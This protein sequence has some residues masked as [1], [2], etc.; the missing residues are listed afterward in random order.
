MVA[1]KFWGHGN[2][3]TQQCKGRTETAF[4]SRLGTKDCSLIFEE[5]NLFLVI[6][7]TNLATKKY[8]QK[9]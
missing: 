8:M 1:L 2:T 7:E 5:Y 4:L 6:L 3:E 9:S